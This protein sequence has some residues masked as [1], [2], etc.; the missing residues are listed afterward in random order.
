MIN[1]LCYD[2]SKVSQREY[3]IMY[4]WCSDT[5]K[6]KINRYY[7]ED[8]RKRSVCA[9]VMMK[10]AWLD[11][12][13]RA[14]KL[15]VYY[16]KYGKPYIENDQNFHFNISHSGKWVVV[17]YGTSSIGVDIEQID[18][19]YQDILDCLGEGKGKDYILKATSKTE[20]S[21]RIIHLWTLKE[22]YVKFLGTGLFTE[23]GSFDIDISDENILINGSGQVEKAI[24]LVSQIF[25]SFYY[26]SI[27]SL[28]KTIDIRTVD[29]CDIYKNELLHYL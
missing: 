17:A 13:R 7:Y 27:C 2:I 24:C 25:D 22:S 14:E 16:N 19:K 18:D 20:R 10:Y 21:R 9:Y 12:G 26:L 3:D 29:F 15:I 23:L 6:E 1:I 4:S 8:D 11:S 5:R 28:E